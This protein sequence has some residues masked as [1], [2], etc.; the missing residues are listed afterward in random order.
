M[1]VLVEINLKVCCFGLIEYL[2]KDGSWNFFLGFIFTWLR[3]LQQIG[4]Y[5]IV[6]MLFIRY[7]IRVLAGVYIK[8]NLLVVSKL[9]SLEP[10]RRTLEP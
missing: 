5:A 3:V 10:L 1:L 2:V 7:L 9:N 6:Y 4:F 8:I